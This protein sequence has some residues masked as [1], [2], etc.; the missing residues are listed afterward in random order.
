MKTRRVRKLQGDVAAERLSDAQRD[1]VAENIKFA[2]Y[3]AF[4][5]M[6]A[7]PGH[8]RGILSAAYYGMC[9]AALNWRDDGTAK[10]T[11]YSAY[12]I[13]THILRYIRSEI[14]RPEVLT[15]FRSEEEEW[16]AEE[17]HQLTRA[18][19][20]RMDL[21]GILDRISKR[22]K[23]IVVLRLFEGLTYAEIGRMMNLTRERVK[24]IEFRIYL[25]LK[26]NT[27]KLE[28]YK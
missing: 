21:V 11:T 8:G 10:F 15:P 16:L 24:Q 17:D 26:Y 25:D 12:A 9:R 7:F 6:M 3:K 18:A 1:L 14:D 28:D 5:Y 20:I 4:R 27:Q 13:R 23:Q 22:N 19:D 2:K